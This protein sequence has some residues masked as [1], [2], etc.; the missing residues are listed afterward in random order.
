[1][2]ILAEIAARRA[3]EDTPNDDLG[4]R[5]VLG[6]FLR[7]WPYI[8]PSSKHL[9]TFV[10]LSVV[11]FLAGTAM[12]LTLISLAANGIMAS[13]P[14]GEFYVFIYG[15]DPDRF[16]NVETLSD[17]ARKDLAWPTVYTAIG[18]A[19]FAVGGTQLLVYYSVWIF[20]AINQRMRVHLIDQ[21]LAQSLSYHATAQTGDAIY[22]VYQDTAMVTAII[23]Y[24]FLEPF[25]FIGRYVGGLVIVAAFSPTL[26]LILLFTA[27][28]MT[29]LGRKFSSPLRLKFRSAR[30]R[31]AALTSWIQESVQGIRVIK[32]SGAETERTSEFDKRSHDAFDAAFDSRVSLNVLGILAFVT[33]AV[34]MLALQ[35]IA[36]TYTLQDAAT[37]ARDLLLAFGFAVW[38]FGTFSAATSRTSDGFVSLRSIVALWGR[39]QDMAIGLNRVFSVLDLEPDIVDAENA[40]PMPALSRSVSFQ[41]VNFGYIDGQTVLHD[42]NFT[43]SI[44]SITAIVGPTGTGKSTLMSLLLR[45]ADPDQGCITV[46]GTDIRDFTVNSLRHGISIAT[47]E[48]ILF[49]ES[50]LNNILY[51]AP[52]ATRQDAIEAARVVCAH[53]FIEALPQGYDTALGERAVKL[54]SGQ[55]QRLVLARAI[56]RDTPILI[57]DEPTAALDAQTE[58]DVLAN[59]QVWSEGRCV[60]L[61]THRLSTIRQAD[62]VIYLRQGTVLAQGR[63][64]ALLA[65]DSGAYKDFVAAETGK[66][67]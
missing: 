32:A 23:R 48:N 2:P 20:Q 25:M 24:V 59:I 7:T 10:F 38:N 41:H 14:L 49:S 29:Y 16:L 15:L 65:L 6:I 66:G 61:I 22:R 3:V 47:Q 51:A 19:L 35:A 17:Q 54:S 21:L 8:K 56:V 9:L 53:D 27:L 63:H 43:A 45:L 5:Q 46:D 50:V 31:N 4:F 11:V 39:A 28:P 62:E 40:K 64:D 1:V 44:G 60:F 34:S 30:E 36:A 52:N 26:A 55:R 37:F 58:H 67:V 33:V 12:G 57:L 42:V 13:Q 18:G